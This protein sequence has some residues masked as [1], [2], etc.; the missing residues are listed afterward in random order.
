MSEPRPYNLD[1]PA[2]V[3]RLHHEL[4]GYMRVSLMDGTDTEGRAHAYAGLCEF[5]RRRFLAKTARG[6]DEVGNGN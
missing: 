6:T 2:E 5:N 3:D 4:Q 1:D